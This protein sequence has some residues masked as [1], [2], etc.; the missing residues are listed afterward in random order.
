[1]WV[2][3]APDGHR[4][5]ALLVDSD[6]IELAEAIFTAGFYDREG[7]GKEWLTT[8]YLFRRQRPRY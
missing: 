2:R 8:E 5:E 1:M 6:V 7:S 3:P 4:G